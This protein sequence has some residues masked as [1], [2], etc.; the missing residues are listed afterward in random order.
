MEPGTDPFASLLSLSRCFLPSS[1]LLS[2]LSTSHSHVIDNMSQHAS[3]DY[4]SYLVNQQRSNSGSSSDSPSN[5]SSSSSRLTS[6]A[7]TQQ[8]QQQSNYYDTSST[9]NS[10]PYAGY[11]GQ[12]QYQQ[13]GGPLLRGPVFPPSASSSATESYSNIVYN[14]RG[15]V[16]SPT[17]Q[18]E[19]GEIENLGWNPAEAFGGDV[20]FQVSL[21]FCASLAVLSWR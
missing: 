3:P 7:N 4:S 9:G 15:Q 18:T 21:T 19:G 20:Q 1:G 17:G 11:S 2:R 14:S 8:H 10:N 16:T 13:G 12:Q 6:S 5:A